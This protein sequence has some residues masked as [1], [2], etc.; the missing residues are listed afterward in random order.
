MIPNIPEQLDTWS[1][2]GCPYSVTYA[3][4]VLEGI[5]REVTKSFHA[6]PHGGLEVGGVLF[7]KKTSENLTILAS[8]PVECEHA[9]GP[10]FTLSA[11][12]EQ[13]LKQLIAA[14][15]SDPELSGLEALGAD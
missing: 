7:G 1:A 14:P 12:D 11:G 2:P 3:Q 6:L 9:S 15:A 10:S 4:A 8:R 13:K 5:R